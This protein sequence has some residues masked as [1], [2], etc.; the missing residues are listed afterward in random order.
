VI[1]VVAAALLFAGVGLGLVVGRRRSRRPSLAT[2]RALR[3]LAREIGGVIVVAQRPA[4]PSRETREMIRTL[5]A[6]RTEL[7]RL[8]D[9]LE[10]QS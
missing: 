3:L 5:T 8:A 1:A 4:E 2:H 10:A 9:E 7:L 6:W